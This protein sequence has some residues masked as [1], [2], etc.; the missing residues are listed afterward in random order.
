MPDEEICFIKMESPQFM[1]KIV[2]E[3]THLQILIF[4]DHLVKQGLFAVK[5]KSDNRKSFLWFP[6]KYGISTVMI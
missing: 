4:Y 3:I 5:G 6:G 1:P 2:P